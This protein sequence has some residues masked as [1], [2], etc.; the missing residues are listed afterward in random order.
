MDPKEITRLGSE[1]Y[2][3]CL[4]E[5]LEKTERGKYVVINVATSDYIV[6]DTGVAARQEFDAKFPGAPSYSVRVGI[7]LVA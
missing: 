6:A 7:P 2:E 4:R 5:T 3:N 1:M